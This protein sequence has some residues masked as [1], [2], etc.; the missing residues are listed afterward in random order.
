MSESL[1]MSYKSLQP[2]IDTSVFLAPTATVIGDVS[3]GEGSSVWFNTILR[4]DIES[5]H[6]GKYTNIQDNSTVHVMGDQATI[7]GDYVTIGHNSVIHCKKIGNNC[8]IGMGA[9]LLGYCEIG[10]NTIIGAGT[11]VT[12]H[13]KIPPNSLVLG[14]PGRIVRPLLDDEIEALH[15]SAVRYNLV[16]QEYMK[17]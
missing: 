15:Q 9:V 12:Q 17:K 6:V 2:K 5:I 16:A 1:V 13:K 4:G 7:I 10:D 14:S 3:I 8:L 11:V